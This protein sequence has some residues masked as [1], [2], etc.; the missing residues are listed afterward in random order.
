MYRRT[1]NFGALA[2]LILDMKLDWHYARAIFIIA[3]AVGLAA[4]VIE[5][6]L[7]G[8]PMQFPTPQP[9][10]YTGPGERHILDGD[11]DAP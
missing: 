11:A 3:R 2:A 6:Q 4:Q 8:K 9:V 1:P 7:N 10:Q 5:E